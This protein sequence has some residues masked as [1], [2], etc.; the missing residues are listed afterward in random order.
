MKQIQNDNQCKNINFSEKKT[1][2]ILKRVIFSLKKIL[3]CFK[4]LYKEIKYE[5]QTKISKFYGYWAEK[6]E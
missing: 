3:T 5:F 1:A 6:P 4:L 2:Y